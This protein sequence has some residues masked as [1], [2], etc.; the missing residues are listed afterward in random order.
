MPGAAQTTWV[1]PV[2]RAAVAL[3]S[4]PA[5]LALAVIQAAQQVVTADSTAPR[6]F[7][8]VLWRIL[9]AWALLG[10]LAPAVAWAVGRWRLDFRARAVVIHAA[11]AAAFALVHAL[12]LAAV[13]TLRGGGSPGFLVA[14]QSSLFYNFVADLLV[15]WAV[16]AVVQA[17]SDSR[18]L[19]QQEAD[20]MALQARL[21]EARLEALRAQLQPHFLHNVLNG[22][23]MLAREGRAEETV[24]VL[25]RLGELLRYLLR[26]GGG[27][28]APLRDEL[29][30][31][32]RY[33]DL[34]RLRLGER[35]QVHLELDPAV[36]AVE[37][38][39]ML[40][41]PLV[42]NAVR[43][44]VAPR[45][46]GGSVRVRAARQGDALLLEVRDD[47]PGLG[48]PGGAPGDVAGLG[49]RITRDRLAQ[50]YGAAARLDL[51]THPDGGCEARVTI[52]W[53]LAT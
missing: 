37:V 26:P 24:A 6:P 30:F 9:P 31:L 48:P 7:L 20:A 8:E 28:A 2:P 15:Y 36:S 43:H 23:A 32:R 47:G 53:E 34:E 22:A 16:A 21:A 39:S 51:R 27:A 4:V 1:R 12:A 38:P 29:D 5:S 52:P 35:L 25:A 14:L 17:L 10:A 33:L 13:K 42:E 50:R 41:Q 46:G 18:S 44:G 3:V 40:L 11:A 49:L 45:P 19:R